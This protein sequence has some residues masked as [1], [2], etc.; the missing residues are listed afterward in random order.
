MLSE[1]GKLGSVRVY[2][3]SLT[4]S[5]SLVV[6]P[7][8]DPIKLSPKSSVKED[9]VMA[10]HLQITNHVGTHVDA[11]AHFIEDGQTIDQLDPS[12]LIGEVVVVDVSQSPHQEIQTDDLDW[13]E[14]ERYQRII[15]KTKN[16]SQGL[17]HKSEF[18]PNYVSVS[19]DLAK[20]L[21]AGN[22]ILVGIDYFGIEK[23]S[24]PGHPVHTKL[25]ENELV[26]I[27]GLDLTRVNQGVYLL[28]CAPLKLAKTDGAPARVFLLED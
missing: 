3:L 7:G 10:S 12:K 25:L 21:V 15:F 18:E 6:W 2:D 17:V 28:V 23:K 9:G 22:F 4:L 1:L 16:T 27:E 24:N 11:P 20:E 26:V 5:P 8:D 13:K 14:V 19:E